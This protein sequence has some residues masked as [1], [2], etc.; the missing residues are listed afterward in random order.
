MTSSALTIAVS[1]SL[2][3]QD[4]GGATLTIQSQLVRKYVAWSGSPRGGIAADGKFGR[5]DKIT[6]LKQRISDMMSKAVAI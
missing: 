3:R 6:V 2:G 1:C 4:R 5:A